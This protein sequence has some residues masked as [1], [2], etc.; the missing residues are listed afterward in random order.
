MIRVSK[1]TVV[2][3]WSLIA[4][5][6]VVGFLHEGK[7]TA[8]MLTYGALASASVGLTLFYALKKA[9]A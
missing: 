8:I 7:S 1:L 9:D 4:V 2:G 6:N 3:P 5:V